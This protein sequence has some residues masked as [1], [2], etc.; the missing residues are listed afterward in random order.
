MIDI[1]VCSSM[2]RQP[3]RFAVADKQT[4]RG[5][6]ESPGSFGLTKRNNP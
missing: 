5:M 3:Y 2:G 4:S 6:M 1:S